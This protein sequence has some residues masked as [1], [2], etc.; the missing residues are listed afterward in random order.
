MVGEFYVHNLTIFSENG[1]NILIFREDRHK[2]MI[3]IYDNHLNINW[4][5]FKD[6]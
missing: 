3:I 2:K 4:M 6:F 5:Q 1:R